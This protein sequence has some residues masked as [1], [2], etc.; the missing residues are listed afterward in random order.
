MTDMKIKSWILIIALSLAAISCKEDIEVVNLPEIANK[1]LHDTTSVY[2]GN[3]EEYPDDISRLPIGIFDSSS[4][5][6]CVLEQFFTMDLF[7]NITGKEEPDGIADF[8]GENFQYLADKANGPYRLYM[9]DH[10]DI[11]VDLAFQNVFFLMESNFYNLYFD[12]F[13]SGVKEPV[14]CIVMASNLVSAVA[15]EDIKTFIDKTGTGVEIIDPM[16]SGINALFEEK[17]LD[18]DYAVGALLPENFISMPEYEKLIR[19]QADKVGMKGLL[20]IFSQEAAGLNQAIKGN[21]DYI[22]PEAVTVRENYKGPKIGPND[23]DIDLILMDRYNFNM[24]DNALLYSAENGKYTNIQLNSIENYVKFH[25][26]TLVERHRRSGSKIPISSIVLSSYLYNRVDSIIKNEI[27]ELYNYNR[28]GIYLY[29]NVISPDIKFIDP[30]QYAAK[31]CY[32]LLRRSG[33]LAL[34]A[35]RTQLSAF[36][37]VPNYNLS[38]QIDNP[39]ECMTDSL[40]LSRKPGEEDILTKIIPFSPRYIDEAKMQLIINHL[41]QTYTLIRNT[42]Y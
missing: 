35:Q 11:M 30:V 27:T 5:A 10:K 26:V 20:Q 23:N 22:D 31:E 15:G 2:Y 12:D 16:Q 28:D 39:E 41:P 14:K 13:K 32:N 38:D 24:K 17:N 4:D 34:R 7:N 29:R 19:K 21:V 42:L 40:K 8:A 9:P 25:L 36:I 3:Y 37:S 18:E 6:F 1:A 33:K